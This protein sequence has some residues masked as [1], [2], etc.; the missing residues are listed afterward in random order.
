MAF[1]NEIKRRI[2]ADNLRTQ[3]REISSALEARRSHLSDVAALL[4]ASCADR[5]LTGE[6]L[7]SIGEDALLTSGEIALHREVRE[8]THVGLARAMTAMTIYDRITLAEL[9]LSHL[10][11]R[12]QPL[13][14]ESFLAPAPVSSRI[15]YVRNAYTDEAFD[16]FATT[17]TEVTSLFADSYEDACREVAEGEAGY[18]ILPWRDTSGAYHRATLALMDVLDLTAV[19]VVTVTD[20]ED[21]PMQYALV[22]RAPCCV[23]GAW[24]MLLSLPREWYP[25]MSELVSSFSLLQLTLSGVHAEPYGNAIH[26]TLRGASAPIALLAWLHLFAPGFVIRGYYPQTEEKDL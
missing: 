5:P 25:R 15:A 19:S 12:G 17:Q 13:T 20:G 6:A 23:N 16:A 10:Q 3:E 22:G 2:A 8:D 4:L 14:Q 21:V 24:E 26:C 7:Q 18:C 1:S 11:R 9:L